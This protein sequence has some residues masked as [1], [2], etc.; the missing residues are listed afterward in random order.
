MGELLDKYFDGDESEAT[1][2]YCFALQAEHQTSG[3]TQEKAF[4]ANAISNVSLIPNGKIHLQFASLVGVIE[5]QGRNLDVVF[6]DILAGRKNSFRVPK[7][8]DARGLPEE[9]PV[10]ESIEIKKV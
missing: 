4:P 10:I 1:G 2:W 6:K 5:I 8:S 9:A 3:P 7:Q